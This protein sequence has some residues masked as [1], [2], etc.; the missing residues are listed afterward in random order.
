MPWKLMRPRSRPGHVRSEEHKARPVAGGDWKVLNHL[1][2]HGLRDFGLLGVE[3]L[4]ICLHLDGGG[5]GTDLQGDID[6]QGLSDE[7]GQSGL[8][9]LAKLAAEASTL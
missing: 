8:L 1:L 2:V 6:S 4:G 3:D 5:G 9:D 7:Q